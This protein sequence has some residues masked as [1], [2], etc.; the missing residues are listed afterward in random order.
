MRLLRGMWSPQGHHVAPVLE[1]ATDLKIVVL[2]ITHVYHQDHEVLSMADLGIEASIL[3]LLSLHCLLLITASLF[4]CNTKLL[5]R[6]DLLSCYSLSL[7][8][9]KSG[10][11]IHSTFLQ[12]S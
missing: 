8:L 10:R 9:F 1:L 4:V 12:L 7:V 5:S 2:H 11:V 6:M 3:A